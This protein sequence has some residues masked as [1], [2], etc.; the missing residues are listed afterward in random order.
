L[1]C[2]RGMQTSGAHRAA[3]T[4][5]F[6][7]PPRS[8]GGGPH[9]AWW[10][11]RP[12]Q[13]N[14]SF[15]EQSVLLPTPLPPRKCAVP[16]P[17]FRGEGGPRTCAVGGALA[18]KQTARR[19]KHS[20]EPDAPSTTLRVVPLPRFAGADKRNSFSRRDARPRFAYHDNNKV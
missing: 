16:P 14:A 20:S 8:G 10:R 6:Y 12:A 9:E 3:R 19:K 2:C 15:G 17:R 7:P 4:N 5:F 18:T 13:M 1:C 11:G